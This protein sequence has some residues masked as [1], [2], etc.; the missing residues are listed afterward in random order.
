MRRSV[1]VGGLVHGMTPSRFARG[2]VWL[3]GRALIARFPDVHGLAVH[4][5]LFRSTGCTFVHPVFSPG[6]LA[7][8]S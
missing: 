3:I 2:R 4:Q 1:V 8:A 5:M 6:Q 7:R